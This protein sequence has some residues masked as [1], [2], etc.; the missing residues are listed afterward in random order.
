MHK[1]FTPELTSTM[2]KCLSAVYQLP[3]TT[4]K[5]YKDIKAPMS[6]HAIDLCNQKNLDT[7]IQKKLIIQFDANHQLLFVKL[8]ASGDEKVEE[9]EETSAR[10]VSNHLEIPAESSKPAFLQ[11][12]SLLQGVI[13][14]VS[15][16]GV[17]IFVMLVFCVAHKSNSLGYIF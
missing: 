15:V 17:F 2:L 11:L 14:K 1:P 4:L 7:T 12:S 9:K 3:S 8:L 5:H 16:K 6:Q 10:I 13:A